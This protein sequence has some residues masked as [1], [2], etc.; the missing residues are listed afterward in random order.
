MIRTQEGRF[1]YEML[2]EVALAVQ[3]CVPPLVCVYVRVCATI[4]CRCVFTVVV[5]AHMC[6]SA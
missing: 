4:S 2:E 1:S 5:C 3:V 6:R